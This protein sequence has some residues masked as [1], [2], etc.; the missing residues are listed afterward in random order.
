MLHLAEETKLFD[1]LSLA[2]WDPAQI[3]FRLYP[4]Y[5]YK[6]DF[7]GGQFCSLRYEW[8]LEFLYQNVYY[9][10]NPNINRETFKGDEF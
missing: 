9:V 4:I 10:K 3:V 8:K 2:A 5:F 7:K 6:T 1:F